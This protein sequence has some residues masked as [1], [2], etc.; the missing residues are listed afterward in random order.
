MITMPPKDVFWSPTEQTSTASVVLNLAPGTS[1]TPEQ[2]NGLYL[3]VS[4]SVPN[5]AVEDITISDQFSN[6]LEQNDVMGTQ[7]FAGGVYL[8][9]REIQKGFQRD[10]QRD[11]QQ[12]LG[13]IMGPE[14]VVVQVYANLNFDQVKRSEQRVE[15]VVDDKGIEVSVEKIQESFSGKGDTVGGTVSTESD[16]NGYPNTSDSGNTESE[17]NENRINYE[18]NRIS[19]DIISQPFVV[20]DLT[21]NVG[22]EPPIPSDPTSLNDD[23]QVAVQNIL[24]NIV[25]SALSNTET[26]TDEQ[27]MNKI[28]V[29]PHE[30]R[31][32][33]AFEEGAS[34]TQNQLLWISVGLLGALVIG[35]TIWIIS[36][37]RKNEEEGFLSPKIFA[38]QSLEIETNQSEELIVKKQ[39]ENL[40]KTKPNEFAK[41]LRTWLAEE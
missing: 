34:N 1:L 28:E 31:G 29:F 30:F 23:A 41:L 27:I 4:K 8:Q 21:I 32:K 7:G 6:V 20:D 14:K 16:I 13:R 17:R 40:A 26:I 15:P 2:V 35:G 37:R 12:L 24:A 22:I 39:L 18:V 33:I 25:R 5:L 10:I 19:E 38:P 36:R 9:Q 11:V 3:L